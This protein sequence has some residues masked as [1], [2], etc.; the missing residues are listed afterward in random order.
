MHWRRRDSPEIESRIDLRLNH[1]YALDYRKKA[2]F[3]EDDLREIG[4]A[5]APIL[6]RNDFGGTDVLVGARSFA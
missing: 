4:R 5:R 6:R 1:D 3:Q 2:T